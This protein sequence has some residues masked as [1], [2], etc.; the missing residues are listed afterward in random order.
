MNPNPTYTSFGQSSP[1]VVGQPVAPVPGD[2]LDTGDITDPNGGSTVVQ[3]VAI[4]L[5][6]T[7]Q[8]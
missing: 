8:P 3:P 1:Q 4:P 6:T 2:I 5:A 7:P